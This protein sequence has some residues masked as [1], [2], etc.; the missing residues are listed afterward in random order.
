MWIIN[1]QLTQR[2]IGLGFLLDNS[3]PYSRENKGELIQN[4]RGFR[5]RLFLKNAYFRAMLIQNIH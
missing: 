2:V 5:M 4:S 1:N 3:I